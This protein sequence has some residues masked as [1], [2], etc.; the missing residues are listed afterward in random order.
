MYHKSINEDKNKCDLL[1]VI[2]SSLKVKPVANIP[3]LLPKNVPQI[4][5]NRESLKHMNFDVELLGDCDVIV[6]EVLMRLEERLKGDWGSIC[7]EKIMM[8]KI[9]GEEAEKVL[10]SDQ[11]LDKSDSFE[12]QDEP[13][14]QSTNKVDYLSENSFI[15]FKPN[16]HVFHGAEIS[17][18]AMRKKLKRLR[19]VGLEEG[20]SK[21]EVDELDTED[22]FTDDDE[23]E[24]DSDDESDT[25]DDSDESEDEDE[26]E[27]DKSKVLSGATD[28][29]EYDEDDDEDFS[30]EKKVVVK[31]E[32]EGL[33]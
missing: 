4:L 21:D 32:S 5:I 23:D 33:K 7:K 17:L 12:D 16:I 25:D 10:F 6:N 9:E 31:K 27:V 14:V 20:L 19:A 1:I 2:G 13:V 30:I 28:G 24:D 26:G 3:H 8:R 22:E 11:N 18:R 29:D 15:Y